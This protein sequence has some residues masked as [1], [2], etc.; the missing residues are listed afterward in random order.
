ML[1]ITLDGDTVR[2]R[3]PCIACPGPHNYTLSRSLFFSRDIFVLSCSFSGIGICFLG[4]ADKV[5]NE[6]VN[7]HGIEADRIIANGK[8]KFNPTDKIAK[9]RPYRTCVFFYNK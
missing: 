9:Y 3:V 5:K 1:E 7:T 6:L 4:R 2:L 8:G